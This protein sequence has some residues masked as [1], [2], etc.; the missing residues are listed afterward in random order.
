MRTE[1]ISVIAL[2]ATAALAGAV[3]PHTLKASLQSPSSRKAAPAFMLSDA[4]AKSVQISDY[5]GK[6]VVLNF[7]ATECGG[8]RLEIPWFVDLDR[9]NK[10][11]NAVVVGVSMDVSYESLKNA[12]EAWSKVKP[13]VQTHGIV[14]PILM[15]DDAVSKAYEITALPATYL[16]DAKGRVAATYVGLINEENVEA[17]VTALLSEGP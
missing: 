2:L 11:A 16:I 7:W 4:G 6:V 3:G 10:N 1:A 14:Y 9:V 17:N 15:G 13:F 8:C 12:S 5:H